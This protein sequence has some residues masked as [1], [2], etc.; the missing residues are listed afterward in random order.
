EWKPLMLRER[1][2][3]AS[4][5]C[6]SPYHQEGE[7]RSSLLLGGSETA[8]R[9]QVSGQQSREASADRKCTG[10]DSR[11]RHEVSIPKECLTSGNR[12]SYLADTTQAP[13]LAREALKAQGSEDQHGRRT[14]V[15][16][17]IISIARERR[18]LGTNAHRCYAGKL[19]GVS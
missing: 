8:I 3:D 6:A 19:A 2:N 9:G 5:S 18:R 1:A 7:A 15:R 12:L 14:L 16:V 17:D 13:V 10:C 4:R 11:R